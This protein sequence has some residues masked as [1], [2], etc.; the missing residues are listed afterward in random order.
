MK[1]TQKIFFCSN[2]D[3]SIPIC[4]ECSEKL[5]NDFKCCPNR[6]LGEDSILQVTKLQKPLRL[7]LED[8]DFRCKYFGCD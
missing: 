8:L 5:K 1:I 6:C 2:E 3:C 4:F 7:M